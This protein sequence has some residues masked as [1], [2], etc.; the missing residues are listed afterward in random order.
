MKKQT[1]TDQAQTERIIH[2]L[3]EN[4]AGS[5]VRRS[6]VSTVSCGMLNPGTMANDDSAG[7]GPCERIVFGKIGKV[8]YPVKSLAKY[9]ARRGFV[10]ETRNIEAA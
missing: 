7:R 3:R 8:S 9:M 1:N 5:L 10:I 6:D 2:F 4:G